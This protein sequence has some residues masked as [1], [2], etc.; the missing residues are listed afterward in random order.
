MEIVLDHI[1]LIEHSSLSLNGLTVI[2]GMNESGKTT[3]G[4][5]LYS[6]IDAVSDLSEKAEADRIRYIYNQLENAA[7]AMYYLRIPSVSIYREKIKLTPLNDY[8][9]L[10]SLLTRNYIRNRRTNEIEEKNALD[11]AVRLREELL[12]LDICLNKD[13]PFFINRIMVER[14]RIDIDSEIKDIIPK[15]ISKAI[16]ILTDMLESLSS[17]TYL[18]DYTYERINQTLNIEF[19]GQIQPIRF[20]VE[21]S[22][23]E[24][25]DD[26]MRCYKVEIADNTVINNHEPVFSPYKRTVFIDDPFILDDLESDSTLKKNGIVP[27]SQKLRALLTSDSKT[28][29]EEMVLKQKLAG[30]KEKIDKII[31]GTFEFSS[32]GDYYVEKGRKLKVA[33]LATGSKMFSILKILLEKGY[34]DSQTMLILDEP[35]AHLHPQWQ[36]QFAE[37]IVLL[38]KELK[39]N[40]LLTSHSSNFVLA[41]DAYMRKYGIEE[42]TSFYK[43]EAMENG[44]VNY[45]CLDDDLNL[46]YQDFLQYFSEAKVLRDRYLRKDGD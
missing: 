10:V 32:S 22:G 46:I 23:I 30:M 8:P 9:C 44:Y 41:L 19:S 31:S 35:E 43:T 16:S 5:A 1:G 20:D 45:T 18:I 25:T 39:V 34:L 40:I 27:H 14:D 6:L 17:E 28:V 11:Y 21:R 24:L 2:T 7:E 29:F 42:Q 36:N 37:M 13:I 26:A 4:K 3:V 33:N 15:Q 38:V 12:D